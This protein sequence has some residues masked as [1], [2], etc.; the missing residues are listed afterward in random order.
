VFSCTKKK[1]PKNYDASEFS[2]EEKLI[3]PLVA[4]PNGEMRKW[5][6]KGTEH[7]CLTT[8]YGCNCN[9]KEKTIIFCKQIG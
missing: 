5:E 1:I 3:A 9:A 6:D 7:K 2:W 4:A 8:G